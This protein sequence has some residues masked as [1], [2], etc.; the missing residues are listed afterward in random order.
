MLFAYYLYAMQKIISTLV[1]LFLFSN[2]NNA[3]ETKSIGDK[4]KTKVN[5]ETLLN[6][7]HK[8]AANADLEG[9][10]GAMDNGSIYIGTDASENWTRAEFKEFCAPYFAKKKTWDFTPLERNIYLNTKNNT[11][12]FDELLKTHMGTCR[13]SGAL[14]LV[15]SEWKI[16]HYVL[17]LTIPNDDIEAVKAAKKEKDDA[18]LATFE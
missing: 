17:S 6:D 4:E 12:W 16:K 3:V 13:G 5:I 15:N 7:W 18:F 1:I 10:I 8:A 11:A 2:C 14:E 9:Y